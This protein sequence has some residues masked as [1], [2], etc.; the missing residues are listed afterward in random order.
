MRYKHSEYGVLGQDRTYGNT[1]GVNGE[2]FLRGRKIDLEIWSQHI[3]R[4]CGLREPKT[5][6]S[7]VGTVK[8][9]GISTHG[10]ATS[11]CLVGRGK[12]EKDAR[13]H[14]YR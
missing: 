8:T 13:Y 11:Q 14:Y 1:V 3:I 2:C 5:L 10:M 4:V 6:N 9:I 12:H 7:C